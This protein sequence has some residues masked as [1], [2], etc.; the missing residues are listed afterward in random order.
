[1]KIENASRTVA[2]PL[3]KPPAEAGLKQ[4]VTGTCRE[5]LLLQKS[6]SQSGPYLHWS[7][8]PYL[9]MV[10]GGQLNIGEAVMALPQARIRERA[11]PGD[12]FGK[13]RGD[14]ETIEW[15]AGCP[16]GCCRH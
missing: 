10:P 2:Q 14:A 7:R 5:E 12:R 13:A 16:A 11:N 6:R 3:A 9:S 1:M 4:S 8:C 15:I